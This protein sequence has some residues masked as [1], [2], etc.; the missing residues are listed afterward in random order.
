MR[1]ESR[2]LMNQRTGTCMRSKRGNRGI[3]KMKTAPRL[4]SC[5]GAL[6]LIFKQIAKE[7][8]RVVAAAIQ[9]AIHEYAI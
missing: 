2:P 1:T 5:K 3:F 7:Q 8:R 9:N 6:F 4:G